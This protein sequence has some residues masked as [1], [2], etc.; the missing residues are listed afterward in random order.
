MTPTDRLILVDLLHNRGSTVHQVI[1]RVK[2]PPQVIK[3]SVDRLLS[4][5]LISSRTS[6]NQLE[7]TE[8][9]FQSLTG[10]RR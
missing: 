10:G 3:S 6:I 2:L 7:I 5:N 4:R 9:G 8:S 1:H